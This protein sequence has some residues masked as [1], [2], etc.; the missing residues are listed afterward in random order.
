MEPREPLYRSGVRERYSVEYVH[1][2]DE[3]T[4]KP[5]GDVIERRRSPRTPFTP[6]LTPMA[7]P[8]EPM[9]IC[10][11][12]RL[13]PPP[14]P[15]VELGARM[16]AEWVPSV[17]DRV[18]VHQ[19][20]IW[21]EADFL[22]FGPLKNGR[23]AESTARVRLLT[24]WKPIWIPYTDMRPSP[25]TTE[26]SC[27]RALAEPPTIT[28]MALFYKSGA[29][30]ATAPAASAAP[31]AASTAAAP[32]STADTDADANADGVRMEDLFGEDGMS[33][34]EDARATTADAGTTTADA[35]EAA[36]PA[37]APGD[38]AESIAP[39]AEDP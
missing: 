10:H 4:G 28:I 37:V 5:L 18:E 9:R 7:P 14:E 8:L 27:H 35:S 15:I 25:M 22:A 19:S 12:T 29:A 36:A 32:A 2:V 3:E 11:S 1:Y 33:D 16:G 23:R 39:S 17:G 31:A 30:A 24:D 21:W 20:D 34:E 13:R 26:P 38:E 6:S